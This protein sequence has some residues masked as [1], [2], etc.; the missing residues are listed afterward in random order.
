MVVER[1]KDWLGTLPNPLGRCVCLPIL[2]A[3]LALRGLLVA[4]ASGETE[5]IR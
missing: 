1:G 3:W 2:D 5:S 4:S